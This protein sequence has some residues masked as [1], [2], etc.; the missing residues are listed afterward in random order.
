M[1]KLKVIIA[2]DEYLICS[3]LY[4]LIDW[5]NLNLEHI[6]SANDGA[7]L[8]KLIIEKHP[9][10]VITDVCMPNL[11]GIELIQNIRKLDIPCRFIVISGYR[12]FEY[13][14]NAMRYDA[15]DYILKPIEAD[16]LN[17][18]LLKVA[19]SIRQNNYP[20]DNS[21]T[22][23]TPP[24]Y[25]HYLVELLTDYKHPSST[26]EDIET[27]N[28]THATSFKKGCFRFICIRL[29]APDIPQENAADN[30]TGI[31]ASISQTILSKMSS[32]CYY[33]LA[34]ASIDFISILL[35]YDSAKENDVLTDLHDSFIASQHL[36]DLFIGMRSTMGIGNC[37]FSLSNCSRS[38]FEAYSALQVRIIHPGE[39][40]I[41]YE[42]LSSHSP[43]IDLSFGEISENILS[44]ID[45]RDSDRLKKLFDELIKTC[46][47]DHEII[48]M[49]NM[50]D[51]LCPPIS[52]AIA[53]QLEAPLNPQYFTRE[54]KQ[55]LASS[56]SVDVL[57]SN[58]INPICSFVN[59]LRKEAELKLKRP[60]RQAVEYIEANYS[61]PLKLEDVAEIVYL[62]PHY[63]SDLFAKE[64]HIT[65]SDY[66]QK[67][68]LEESKR[69][70]INTNMNIAE[71]A[72][73]IGYADS[74]YFSKL[75]KKQIG[76]MPKEYRKLYS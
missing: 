3:L 19:T 50:L 65:F 7:T 17:A 16:E 70:L 74:R 56:G 30:S 27:F 75:F 35:N 71:I 4:N 12:Q 64:L 23:L 5:E 42:N 26:L 31:S 63:F 9:D 2:D 41:F 51:A 20:A 54:L 44:Y 57:Y 40:E 38:Y 25:M 29:D 59:Q 47:F 34:D 69:L 24:G 45:I 32:S 37:V 8:Y 66:I 6:G 62:S 14:R 33:V 76:I 43:N 48:D 61:K 15:D 46:K 21:G 39:N 28:I 22:L 52:E 49:L 1:N 55:A 18:A 68:R 53:P 58:F 13:A 72:N 73:T 36:C 60:I 11:N 10:I 67:V